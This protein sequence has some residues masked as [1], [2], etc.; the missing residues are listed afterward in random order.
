MP[1]NSSRCLG[2]WGVCPKASKSTEELSGTSGS[3]PDVA[4]SGVLLGIY[5]IRRDHWTLNVPTT[6]IAAAEGSL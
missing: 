1:S 6:E 5:K 2:T 4:M 3:H